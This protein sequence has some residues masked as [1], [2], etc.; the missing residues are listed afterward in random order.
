MNALPSPSSSYSSDRHLRVVPPPGARKQPHPYRAIALETSAKLAVNL[1]LSMAAIAALVQLLPYRVSQQAKLTEL[2]AE[3]A[4]TGDRVKR[5]Q[6]EFNHNFDPAQAQAV[7][8]EQTTRIDA[9]KRNILWL[10]NGNRV[11]GVAQTP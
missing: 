4:S 10:N 5:L 2:Q 8:E 3:V 1:V 11:E 7:M 9:R 6:T